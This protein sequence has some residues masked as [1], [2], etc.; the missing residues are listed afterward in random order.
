MC[1][2]ARF[3]WALSGVYGIVVLQKQTRKG[4]THT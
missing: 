3:H 1:V 2:S 4:V